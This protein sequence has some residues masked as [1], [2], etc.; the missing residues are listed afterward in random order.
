MKECAMSSLSKWIAF[1]EPQ[2]LFRLT[3]PNLMQISHVQRN[4]AFSQHKICV[5]YLGAFDTSYLDQLV[6]RGLKKMYITVTNYHINL[7]GWILFLTSA[8]SF[9]SL[10]LVVVGRCL[11]AFF[12]HY[13]PRI[14]GT[15]FPMQRPV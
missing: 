1:Y 8:I 14:Y 9:A 3:L 7:A 2:Q 10:A 15:I 13:V 4:P 6:G 5:E 12:S 11:P